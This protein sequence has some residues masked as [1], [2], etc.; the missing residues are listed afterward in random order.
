[1]YTYWLSLVFFGF[2]YAQ[3]AEYVRNKFSSSVSPCRYTDRDL[4]VHRLVTEG[5]AAK[6]GGYTDK[7][8][9]GHS[10][11]ILMVAPRE[12]PR[13]D[14]IACRDVVTLFGEACPL[15]QSKNLI[16]AH[17]MSSKDKNIEL[18]A[19]ALIATPNL[20]YFIVKSFREDTLLDTVFG[21]IGIALFVFFWVMV[22]VEIV[23]NK[24]G[25]N[26]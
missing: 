5:I 16:T 13:K 24:R 21:Y 25:K 2:P 8:R 1:M 22:I 12:I 4:S 11:S 3:I 14:C 10:S 7:E 18:I 26:E 20:L 6:S 17:D 9:R 19:L 15:Q 23:R